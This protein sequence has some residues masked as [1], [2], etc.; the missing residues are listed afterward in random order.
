MGRR[1]IAYDT[2]LPTKRETMLIARHLGICDRE[3]ATLCMEVWAWADAQTDD[4][5]VAGLVP[6]DLDRV[7]HTPGTGEA[8]LSAGWLLVDSGGLIFPNWTRWNTSPAKRRIRETTRKRAVRE[9]AAEALEKEP[10]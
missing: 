7:T 3:A 9:A 5:Y 2:T 4:G 1:W 6:A 10:F 8:F